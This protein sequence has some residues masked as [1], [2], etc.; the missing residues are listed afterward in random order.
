M[1]MGQNSNMTVSGANGIVKME[2]LRSITKS[3]D[4]NMTSM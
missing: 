4:L 1:R 2:E 3:K